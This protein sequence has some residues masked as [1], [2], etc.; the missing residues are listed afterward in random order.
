MTGKA[1]RAAGL[2]CLPLVLLA[3][4]S[5]LSTP[6][7]HAADPQPVLVHQNPAEGEVIQQPAFG[8]QLCF[9]SPVNF[10]DMDMGGDFAFTVTEPDGLGN[11]DV[12]QPDGYGITIYPGKPTGETTSQWKFHDRLT[13]PDAQSSSGTATASPTPQPGAT[14]PAAVS[15]SPAP[16][17]GH[18]SASAT[19]NA[20]PIAVGSSSPDILKYS[21]LTIGAAGAAGVI[22]LIGYL[23]RRRVGYDPH[24]EK[25]G[26]GDDHH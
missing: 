18:P 13:S 5:A 11:R 20:S 7:A 21:L 17:S 22:L 10:K 2:W 1:M 12:F 4:V 9:A 26:S 8:I 23:I 16:T 24:R 6:P 14:T 19:P 25:P 3:L 15:A